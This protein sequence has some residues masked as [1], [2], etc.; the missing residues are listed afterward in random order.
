MLTTTYADFLV[1]F[2]HRLD[3]LDAGYELTRKTV[4]NLEASLT[5][6]KNS[7]HWV[8]NLL[9]RAA[10]MIGHSLLP[11]R[12]KCKYQLDILKSQTARGIQRV[13]CALLWLTYPFLMWIP[14]RG[15]MCLLLVLEPQL[16]PVFRVRREPFFIVRLRY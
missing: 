13:L 16:R 5:S 10:L 8:T 14:L 1:S 12:V 3:R 2:N 9:V 11:E 15:M 4:H 7:K 6:A